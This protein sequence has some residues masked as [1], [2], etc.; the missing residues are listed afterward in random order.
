MNNRI[1][2]DGL[3]EFYHRLNKTRDLEPHETERLM[4]LVKRQK[5]AKHVQNYRE[6]NREALNEKRRQWARD[7]PDRNRDQARRWRE[8]NP[9]SAREASRKWR[10]RNPEQ[11]KASNVEMNESELLYV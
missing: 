3:I 4:D 1:D 7:N 8:D 11:V 2:F 5:N 10:E 9:H 6:K